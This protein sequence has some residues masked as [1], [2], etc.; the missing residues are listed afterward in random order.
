MEYLYGMRIHFIE[1]LETHPVCLLPAYDSAPLPW[2]RGHTADLGFAPV[3]LVIDLV[4]VLIVHS[5][6][7]QI[8]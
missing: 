8:V 3:D 4:I 6:S 2:P 1:Y 5:T 7:G